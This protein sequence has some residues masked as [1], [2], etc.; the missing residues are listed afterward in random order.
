MLAPIVIPR[1][2][3]IRDPAGVDS[4]CIRMSGGLAL[5]ARPPATVRVAIRRRLRVNI[6]HNRS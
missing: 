4:R 3:E 5:R 1:A 2:I 6:A